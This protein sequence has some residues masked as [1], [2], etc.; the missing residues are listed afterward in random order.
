MI[1]EK[2]FPYTPHEEKLHGLTHGLGTLFGLF[3]F[4]ELFQ[5]A[6]KTGNFEQ[7]VSYSVYT[8]SM[9]ILFLSSTIYH[10]TNDVKLKSVFKK[11]DH[12]AIYVFIAGCYTPILISFA[13][14]KY[15]YLYLAV[16]WSVG[17]FGVLYKLISRKRRILFSVASYVTMGL[18]CLLIKDTV[19]SGLPPRSLEWLFLGGGF[20]L[21][22]VFFYV[23]KSMRY[24]HVFWHIF[25][26]M[27]CYAHYRTM[28][29]LLAI[30]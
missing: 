22:G 14:E 13:S 9:I 15:K 23:A 21:I 19:L 30:V 17:L 2:L 8:I 18:L 6:D 11:I 25:V 29:G 7:T 12:M 1:R 24:H 27:G 28:S 4:F 20:Y 3:V 16:V 10:L 26:L 5:L